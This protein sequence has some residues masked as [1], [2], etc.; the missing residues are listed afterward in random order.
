MDSLFR[1]CLANRWAGF[2]SSSCFSSPWELVSGN[3]ATSEQTLYILPA[4]LSPPDYL[5]KKHPAW[6]CQQLW[7]GGWRQCSPLAARARRTNRSLQTRQRR[8]LL[9]NLFSEREN[10][11]KWT[12]RLQRAL[13][14]KYISSVLLHLI[15]ASA[16]YHLLHEVSELLGHVFRSGSLQHQQHLLIQ[17]FIQRRS[18]ARIGGQ[19]NSMRALQ[20]KAAGF[21]RFLLSVNSFPA[22]KFLFSMI[23]K[24]QNFWLLQSP[25]QCRR[26]PALEVCGP[27]NFDVI[28]QE[29]GAKAKK[30]S[31]AKDYWPPVV[32]V[33]EPALSARILSCSGSICRLATETY[34]HCDRE[35]DRPTYFIWYIYKTV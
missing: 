29:T 7:P 15:K 28:G 5:C 9:Q 20:K 35:E 25:I 21:F 16:N 33:P 17:R 8:L 2:T 11:E 27:S 32:T 13:I 23:L 3:T 1:S 26:F 30:R 34:Q 14:I 31:K 22:S 19:I 18:K 10:K 12:R 4:E 6:D 24:H